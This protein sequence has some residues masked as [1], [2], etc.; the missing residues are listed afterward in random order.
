VTT[1]PFPT[2][3]SLFSLWSSLWKQIPLRCKTIVVLL[4]G[5]SRGRAP[6][7]LFAYSSYRSGWSYRPIF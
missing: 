1:T 2:P 7:L 3:P 5:R 6:I 4:E